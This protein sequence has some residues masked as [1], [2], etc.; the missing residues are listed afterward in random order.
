[1]EMRVQKWQ[2]G[3]DEHYSAIGESLK[4]IELSLKSGI[5]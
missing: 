4:K 1:M 3:K 5:F 2:M